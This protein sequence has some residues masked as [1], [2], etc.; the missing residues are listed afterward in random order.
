MIDEVG[1]DEVSRCRVT[2][3]N[4]T[5]LVSQVLEARIE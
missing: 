2:N 5:A 3:R 1:G 4:R